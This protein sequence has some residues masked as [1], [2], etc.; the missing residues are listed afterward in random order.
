MTIELV[1]I[2]I[3]GLINGACIVG[4][5]NTTNTNYVLGALVASF[6]FLLL[7]FTIP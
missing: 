7:S 1:V 2:T 5:Y 4:Y 3:L 6:A